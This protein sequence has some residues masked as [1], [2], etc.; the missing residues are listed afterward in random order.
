MLLARRL[1]DASRLGVNRP[2]TYSGQYPSLSARRAIQYS[3][4][5]LFMDRLRREL[6]D[7]TFWLALKAYTRKHA[8][9]T[10]NSRD[11]QKAFEGAARRD[12]SQLF[13]EWVY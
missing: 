1:E 5:A 8:G 3:K 12:L 11:F 2:L 6:G 9:G 4:G 13:N 10:V 7:E